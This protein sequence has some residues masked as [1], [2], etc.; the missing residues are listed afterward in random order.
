M[1]I[2]YLIDTNV[3]IDYLEGL[4]PSNGIKKID[5]FLNKGEI[6]LSVINQIE[7]L[8]FHSL[9]PKDTLIIESFIKKCTVISLTRDIAKQT[10]QLRR[11]HRK[12]L[13]DSIIA[14]TAVVHNLKVV[15]RNVKDF[16]NIKGLK[17]INPYTF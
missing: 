13:P 8:S 14:A 5:T 4:L 16:Q 7:L 2:A 6:G 15:S 3:V 17:I 1:G 10:I 9:S 11:L 12:K